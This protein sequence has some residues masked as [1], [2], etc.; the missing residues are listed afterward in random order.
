MLSKESLYQAI[1]NGEVAG[2]PAWED[3]IVWKNKEAHIA[4][5]SFSGEIANRGNIGK[6]SDDLVA[7]WDAEH[8]EDPG[9]T[10]FGTA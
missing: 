9:Q 4:P 10:E 6:A 8:H 3:Y 7:L 2:H 5:E 1:R